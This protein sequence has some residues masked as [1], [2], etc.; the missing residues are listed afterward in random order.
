MEESV[1]WDA[2]QTFHP[3]LDDYINKFKAFQR[4]VMVCAF[5]LN[6][7]FFIR[8]AKAKQIHQNFRIVLCTAS[9]GFLLL[10]PTREL[11]HY[12]LDVT[13]DIQNRAMVNVLCITLSILHMLSFSSSMMCMNLIA[14]EQYFAKRWV[15][16]YEN[17][18]KFGWILLVIVAINSIPFGVF[19]CVY[20][21]YYDNFSLLSSYQGCIPTDLH[22]KFGVI[23]YG[24]CALSC[25]ISAAVVYIL[26]VQNQSLTKNRLQL[27][28]LKA[29]YQQTV[30]TD[31]NTSIT[32]SMLGFMIIS[33]AGL[34]L[35]IYEIKI[36]Y[37][38]GENTTEK[39]FVSD[40]GYALIDYYGIYHILCFLWCNK[41]M[42]TIV[43][44]DIRRFC[45]MSNKTNV[46]GENYIQANCLDAQTETVIYFEQLQN[47]WS[48]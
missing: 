21:L 17:L 6:I 15:D 14:V 30:N 7:Y 1:R 32:P 12:L 25:S 31:L 29:R 41:T 35:G 39:M 11:E 8:L 23:G 34:C 28:T 27:K 16:H 40:L 13:S 18:K 38:Y 48:K 24:F 37:M 42:K 43:K 33:I 36:A 5:G 3:E 10:G 47:S 9:T 20:F 26:K 45:C 44:A 46:P 22:S 19:S 2:M 4:C